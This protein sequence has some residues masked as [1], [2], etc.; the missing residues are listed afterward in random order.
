MLFRS[1]RVN[2][3]SWEGK[4]QSDVCSSRLHKVRGRVRPLWVFCM[5]LFPT[6]LQEVV[7]LF[8][9]LESMI[10]WSQGNSQCEDNWICRCGVTRNNTLQ[11]PLTENMH[12]R[13][14]RP[15][16]KFLLGRTRIHPSLSLIEA[17][18]RSILCPHA[19]R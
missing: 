8:S 18:A 6:F 19:A 13:G 11:N 3:T 17:S 9:G 5:R 10:S 1:L 7:R 12:F 2:A 14:Y 16:P 4:G 15:S